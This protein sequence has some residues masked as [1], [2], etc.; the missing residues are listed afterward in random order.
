MLK[1]RDKSIE[2]DSGGYG[3]FLFHIPRNFLVI[4]N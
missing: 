3:L 4:Y 1:D 2:Y